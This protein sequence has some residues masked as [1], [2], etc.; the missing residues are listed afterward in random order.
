MSETS[1]ASVF[2]SGREQHVVIPA[3]FR[4]RSDQVR[5]RRDPE[6]GDV[7]LSEIPDIEAVYAALDAA[8]LPA[9]FLSDR[10]RDRRP[11]EP[12]KI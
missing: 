2:T 4:F 7:I 6:S 12:G 8:D 1:R 9:D 10:D 5:I 3:G 11:P